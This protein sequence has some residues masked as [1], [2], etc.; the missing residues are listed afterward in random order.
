MVCQSLLTRTFPTLQCMPTRM[1]DGG[2]DALRIST[3]KS[4]VIFQVKYARNP[5]A[6]EDV[7]DWII[8]A[9]EPEIPK[10][11]RLQENSKIEQYIVITNVS[12]TSHLH[13][14]RIDRVQTFLNQ[15]FTI[16]SQCWWRDD[17]DRRLDDAF[18]LKLRYPD[19]MTGADAFRLLWTLLGAGEAQARRE[20]ALRAYMSYHYDLD[21]KVKFKEVGLAPSALFDLFIDVPVTADRIPRRGIPRAYED[22]TYRLARIK[23]QGLYPNQGVH[24]EPVRDTS[25]SDH[26]MYVR[27]L[28]LVRTPAGFQR[29]N[30]GASELLLDPAFAEQNPVIVLEG[31]PGQGKSTLSQY[32]AQVQR[33]R[34]LEFQDE[35]ATLPKSIADSPLMLPIKLELRDVALWLNGIDPWSTRQA[36]NHHGMPTLEAA[37][38]AHIQRYSGG[39]EFSVADLHAA[40]TR[41]PALIVLDALDEVADLEDRKRVVDEVKAAITRLRQHN[42]G[43][44]FFITSRPTAIAK[45]PSF[46]GERVM[47]LSLAPIDDELAIDYAN[48][49]AKARTLDEK[50]TDELISVL[51]RRL[52]SPH[53][54]ELAKNTMQL[55]ILLNLISLRGPSLPDKR[56]DLYDTY[57]QVFMDRESEKDIA[58]R[59]NREFLVD[60]H[61]YLG[62]YLHARAE[63][64]RSSGR[65]STSE[66]EDLIRSYMLKQQQPADRFPVL[67]NAVDRIFAIVSRVEGMWEFEVQPLQE[68]FAARYLYDTAPY[69]PVGKERSGT[70][71]DIFD[72][73]APNSYWLNV[74][75]FFAGCF[76]KGELLD[77]SDRLASLVSTGSTYARLLSISLVQ[78]W[79]FTQST[80][81]T[82]IVLAAT[83]DRLGLRWA[84]NM[85][86]AN[87]A[88]PSESLQLY[89][90]RSIDAYAIVDLILQAISD[91]PRTAGKLALCR[92]ARAQRVPDHIHEKWQHEL[93]SK[94]GAERLAHLEFGGWLGVIETLSAEGLATMID[95]F[96]VDQQPMAGALVIINNGAIEKVPDNLIQASVKCLLDKEFKFA[97]DS[98]EPNPIKPLLSAHFWILV[99]SA[100]TDKDRPYMLDS[101]QR[102]V[103][104]TNPAPDRYNA[105]LSRQVV[106][107]H[108]RVN[109]LFKALDK[110]AAATLSDWNDLVEYFVASYGQSML[111]NELA[112]MAGCIKAGR[113][114]GGARLLSDSAVPLVTRTRYA[115][116]QLN[117]VVWWRDQIGS[118]ETDYDRQLW[119]LTLYAWASPDVI[120]ELLSEIQ[121]QLALIT[122]VSRA[123]AIEAA[124][125]CV[126]YSPRS[127]VIFD[128]RHSAALRKL[129]DPAVICFLYDRMGR[130]LTS[131]LLLKYVEPTASAAYMANIIL[132][133]VGQSLIANTITD[134]MALRLMARGYALGADKECGLRPRVSRGRY[135]SAKL[136]EAVIEDSWNMPADVLFAAQNFVEHARP[137]PE[138]VMRI[139]EREGWF[140]ADG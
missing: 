15:N 59:D 36:D 62:Y 33:A 29:I 61:T 32:L 135:L 111:A 56:T 23:A 69:S 93:D 47:H 52:R 117:R 65:I 30:T 53:I 14:G 31:A 38:A 5:S 120:I 132:D 102:V 22:A 78:D 115:K 73:I 124:R 137:N 96:E 130:N 26:M 63:A 37:I 134:E 84:A 88:G 116:S 91:S 90:Q 82:E 86:N 27:Q 17:L 128:E 34:L 125:R 131:E 8:K 13:S 48:R 114:A 126:R 20:S 1:P 85:L 109:E 101:L 97:S 112:V 70:K 74:T 107:L 60:L 127:R 64:D 79:V 110:D 35:I 9:V 129:R 43:V 40:L 66:L 119:L 80:R 10:I 55:T 92:L 105:L 72:G 12:G 68:Y 49:W 71:P 24:V 44:R 19:L 25:E 67:T 81:A 118:F 100:L 140:G 108:E 123:S 103:V 50:D 6:I 58:V 138:P 21:R 11:K 94:N 76:S 16:P 83:F 122:E 89:F 28:Y 51:R 2:R 104:H 3:N 87:V 99:L 136:A 42:G 133:Y 75:R 113:Q 45:S 57:F 54:A 41:T 139:A 77:L 121:E 46:R 4:L 7:A 18:D 95:S 39:V 98:N 106:E